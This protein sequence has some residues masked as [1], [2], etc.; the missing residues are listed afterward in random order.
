M[1]E[2]SERIRRRAYEIWQRE[3]RG[4]GGQDRH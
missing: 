4:E 3:G 2:T 1:D